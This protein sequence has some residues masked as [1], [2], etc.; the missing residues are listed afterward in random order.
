MSPTVIIVFS[1]ITSPTATW[2][3]SLL[4]GVKFRKIWPPI[5]VGLAN[6]VNRTIKEIVDRPRPPTAT[7]ILNETNPSMPSGH[8]AGAAALAMCITLLVRKWWTIAVWLLALIIG[9]S[10]IYFG[11]HWPSDVIVGWIVG[12][13]AVLLGWF[14]MNYFRQ[15]Q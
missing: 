15:R 2:L 9:L 6:I 12:A 1:A 3:Y 11:V 4:V 8:A 10:R 7:Y 14:T 13:V 5:L